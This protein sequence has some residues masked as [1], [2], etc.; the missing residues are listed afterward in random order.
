M[1]KELT[2]TYKDNPY[3]EGTKEH[4][5]WYFAFVHGLNSETRQQRWLDS[6]LKIA[7]IKRIS[8]TLR[9]GKVGIVVFWFNKLKE[10]QC[11][12]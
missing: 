3:L 5:I 10:V 2:Y 7:Q 1:S 9:L 6:E 11:Q 12:K 4:Q 8:H